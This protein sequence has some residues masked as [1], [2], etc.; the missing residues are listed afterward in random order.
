[1]GPCKVNEV[2]YDQEIIDIAHVVDNA[3]L[4]GKTFLQG[5]VII[6]VTLCHTVLAQLV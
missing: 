3:K 1:M 6:R 2:P 4:I 5:P